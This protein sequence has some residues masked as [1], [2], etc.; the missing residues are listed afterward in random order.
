M[1]QRSWVLQLVAQIARRFDGVDDFIRLTSTDFV[2][3]FDR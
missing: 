3:A 2:T 1:E